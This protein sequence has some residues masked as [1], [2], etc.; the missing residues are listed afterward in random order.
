MRKRVD[1]VVHVDRMKSMAKRGELYSEIQKV[2]RVHSQIA[3]ES[4]KGGGL[5]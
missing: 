2:A 1:V 4:G 3:G 5:Y